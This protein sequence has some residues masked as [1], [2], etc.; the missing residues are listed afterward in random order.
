LNKAS[1]L[2]SSNKNQELKTGFNPLGYLEAKGRFRG[3][4]IGHNF[5]GCDMLATTKKE[6]KKKQGRL[7]HVQSNQVILVSVYKLN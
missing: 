6:E 1:K 4:F 5:V 3:P 7:K 2:I